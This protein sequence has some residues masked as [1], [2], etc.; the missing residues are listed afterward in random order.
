MSMDLVLV[1]TDSSGG[2]MSFGLLH[3]VTVALAVGVAIAIA[4]VWTWIVGLGF[5]IVGL[6]FGGALGLAFD[7]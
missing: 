4:V 7:Q 1:H 6:G 2:S 5:A 3:I